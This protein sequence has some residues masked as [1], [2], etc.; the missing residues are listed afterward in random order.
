MCLIRVTKVDVQSL[1]RPDLL[2]FISHPTSET[3]QYKILFLV[4]MCTF[5]TWSSKDIFIPYPVSHTAHPAF[6]IR[7]FS[8]PAKLTFRHFKN[9]Q[10]H[11]PCMTFWV[12]QCFLEVSRTPQV[13][14]VVSLSITSSAVVSTGLANFASSVFSL[15]L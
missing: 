6:D 5:C 8:H 12:N 3:Y 14:F 2:F 7:L 4:E 11:L 13:I 15:Y 10:I 9:F 1:S